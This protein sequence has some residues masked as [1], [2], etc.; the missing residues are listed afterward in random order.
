M[1]RQA[2]PSRTAAKPRATEMAEV[3]S[4]KWLICPTCDKHRRMPTEEYLEAL[5][6][7][8]WSC[9]FLS[10]KRFASCQAPQEID[11]DI[12]SS[13]A[14]VGYEYENSATRNDAGEGLLRASLT[15][16]DSPR[17]G[18]VPISRPEF[19]RES[20]KY[21]G[22]S[23]EAEDAV[24]LSL[25]EFDVGRSMLELSSEDP[26]R[27][28]WSEHGR[29]ALVK[30][31]VG[32]ASVHW[33]GI[34]VDRRVF[35]QL[36]P[37]Q[38]MSSGKL[39]SVF[40]LGSYD[41][42]CVGL[43][44]VRVWP[45]SASTSEAF[46]AVEVEVDVDIPPPA[47][48]RKKFRKR[49]MKELTPEGNSSLETYQ[50]LG[51]KRL[52][53]GHRQ[54]FDLAFFDGKALMGGQYVHG[55]VLYVLRLGREERWRK[56]LPAAMPL[57]KRLTGIPPGFDS[58][59]PQT[60]RSPVQSSAKRPKVER[61][62]VEV[63]KTEKS[64]FVGTSEDDRLDAELLAEIE[65][66]LPLP[67]TDNTTGGAS[68]VGV[69]TV[70]RL[71]RCPG[72][73]KTAM[74]CHTVSSI[75]TFGFKSERMIRTRDQ[76]RKAICEVI[77]GVGKATYV[78][79][80][81]EERA[82]GE[83]AN[84]AYGRMTST[85]NREGLRNE[86]RG[87]PKF[88]IGLRSVNAIMALLP[89]VVKFVS[90]DSNKDGVCGRFKYFKKTRSDRR[91]AARQAFE[92]ACALR[93]KQNRGEKIRVTDY[94]GSDAQQAIP[95]RVA[96]Q[97][98]KAVKVKVDPTKELPEV[99]KAISKVLGENSMKVRWPL[100]LCGVC[101]K[102]DEY[103]TNLM[104]TCARCRMSVH[105]WC[106]GSCSRDESV[107]SS[108]SL[109]LCR[110]CEHV[111]DVEKKEQALMEKSEKDL[112]YRCK[113]VAEKQRRLEITKKNIS[114]SRDP[115]PVCCLCPVAGGPLKKT[116]CGKWAH[117]PCAIWTPET[118]IRDTDAMEPIED[119]LL[120][121]RSRYNLKCCICKV[122]YGTCIQ[123]DKDKCYQSYHP[124]C[125]RI[126]GY[127]MEIQT[128]DGITI[129]T[130]PSTP[131]KPQVKVEGEQLKS[132]NEKDGSQ[133]FTAAA[134]AVES[135]PDRL[136][137]PDRA[138]GTKDVDDD[139][140]DGLV[141]KFASFCKRHH[142]LGPPLLT[143]LGNSISEP[144][145]VKKEPFANSESIS[146]QGGQHALTSAEEEEDIIGLTGL[147]SRCKSR[148]PSRPPRRGV[149]YVVGSFY[150][151]FSIAGPRRREAE[152]LAR[153]YAVLNQNPAVV[154]GNGGKQLVAPM[155]IS[156]SPPGQVL[157]LAEQFKMMKETR[158]ERLIFGKSGIA[159]W[160]VFTRVPHK[161]GDMMAEYCGELIPSS[162]TDERE[163]MYYRENRGT[164]MFSLSDTQV[165]DATLCGGLAHL[166]NHSCDP[167]CYSKILDVDGESHIVI[168][169]LDDIAACTEL[170]YDYR[171]DGKD[172][173]PCLCGS[174]KC[175]GFV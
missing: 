165:I 58:N 111:M 52:L 175:R 17:P 3:G 6:N 45:G 84:E 35:L 76:E 28:L 129:V 61:A 41:W 23:P 131:A 73:R 161:A 82:E 78:V 160:G 46:P 79:R 166:I 152:V 29:L 27:G 67:F 11:G 66:A 132:L 83:S 149:P 49:R 155:E 20:P 163:A 128:V 162:M 12:R 170:S 39:V 33:P 95:L 55:D 50:D 153:I 121:H 158:R 118:S 87:P 22:M 114:D 5:K 133:L 63:L 44:A 150:K 117:L 72:D 24:K 15:V 47:R 36:Y 54:K 60:P 138:G 26:A 96:S 109:W 92:A 127:H 56:S 90:N 93:D 171:W 123:C 89:N 19:A 173:T 148:G 112:H 42:A 57:A 85:W 146:P 169:A 48:T 147:S 167:N 113:S 151:E 108:G 94:I 91:E 106:Y 68:A 145:N 70:H 77:A 21:E 31:S 125:A 62:K 100:H 168:H 37:G 32:K 126:M 64:K 7:H 122:S 103:A 115:P 86:D 156:T 74:N 14:Q 136:S 141:V 101:F 71:G 107:I 9:E 137:I 4:S 25:S 8:A 97:K 43:A 105:Q 119:V 99:P 172:G 144:F 157:S 51:M 13:F 102:G 139:E 69:V 120:I 159:G 80:C 40:F 142:V 135:S 38:K 30:I 18:V 10:D 81:G 110:L 2:A 16:G 98:K 104:V 65:N 143:L 164:Y 134:P 130:P 34:L 154:R 174:V 1:S 116:S 75:A 59:P 140:D 53:R 88:G 124:L